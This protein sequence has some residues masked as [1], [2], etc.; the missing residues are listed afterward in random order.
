LKPSAQS[1]ATLARR[2]ETKQNKEQSIHPTKT[3]SEISTKTFNH[4]KAR[5]IDTRIETQSATGKAV[6]CHH[7][8][9]PTT[10]SP[11][12]SNTDEAQEKDLKTNYM[13]MIVVLK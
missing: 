10:A 1:Q 8:S 13:K 7:Y 3:N 11:E 9:H 12:Y 2:L 5:C 6:V 4:L